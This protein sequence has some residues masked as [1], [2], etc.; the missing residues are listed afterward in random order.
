VLVAQKKH[1]KKN[2]LIMAPA[3]TMARVFV[4]EVVRVLDVK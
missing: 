2:V 3:R 4:M 1:A